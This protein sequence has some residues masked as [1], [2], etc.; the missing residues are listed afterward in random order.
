[1]RINSFGVGQI[2]DKFEGLI[3]ILLNSAQGLKEKIIK[4]SAKEIINTGQIEVVVLFGNNKEKVA[5]SAQKNGVKFEDLDLGFG[6]LTLPAAEIEKIN[7][8]EG[9][10][11]AELPK[12]LFTSDIN[13][14]K[15]SCIPQAWDRYGLSGQKI[16]VGFVDTGIDYLHPAFM[17]T[18]GTTRIE[19]IYDL[20]DNSKVYTKEQINAAIKSKNPLS[21]VMADDPV[22]HGTHVAGIACGGGNIPLENRGVAYN[23]SIAMVKTTRYGNANYAL[24]TQIM[25]GI[26]FLID[27]SQEL[28]QPTVINISMSTND[29]AHN[30]TSLLEQ[31]IQVMSSLELVTIVIATGNEG[32]AAHHAGGIITKEPIN[33]DFAIAEGERGVILQLYKPVLAQLSL[34]IVSPEGNRSGSIRLAEG[35]NQVRIGQN[36]GLIYNT[37]PKP[38]D[39]IGEI[40]ITLLPIGETFEQGGT[41]S[42]RITN[43]SEYTGEYDLWMPISEGLSPDTK[44]LQPNVYNT[45]GIPATVRGAIS[46]GSYDYVTNVISAFSGRG[47]LIQLNGQFKPDLVAPGNAIISAVPGGSFDTKSGTSMATPHVTGSAALLMEWGLVKGNDP[48]LYGD[49]LKYYL[50]KGARRKRLDVLY[51][52]PN[53]GYGELCVEETLNLL[54]LNLTREIDE[55]RGCVDKENRLEYSFGN[56]YVRLPSSYVLDKN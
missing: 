45:L 55:C 42:L 51:P 7:L 49:R 21:I 6:I 34:E 3:N 46:V 48:F 27:K 47:R 33:I 24:S 41:W 5:Q 50:I 38:F 54:S 25:R 20:T 17:N 12:A 23:S 39:I 13:S 2:K 37:G 32:E 43:E 36:V 14:N 19:F 40:V 1:M 52:N 18:D 22:G 56:V 44:F 26:K 10:S 53:W 31:Y 28:N 8:I 9:I 35:L 15:A 29:G 4:V 11:Y 16:L 30:G